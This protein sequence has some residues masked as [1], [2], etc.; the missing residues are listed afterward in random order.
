MNIVDRIK[1][2]AKERG[3]SLSK[4][5]ED[6]GLAANSIYTWT[7][8]TPGIDKIKAVADYFDVSVDYLIGR[9]DKKHY[10]DLSEKEEKDLAVLAQKM[11]DGTTEEAEV[12]FEGEPMTEEAKANLRT[13]I[14]TALEINKRA[15][16]KSFT[17]KKYRGS[18]DK[19]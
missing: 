15:A 11:L 14:L 6:C 19:D 13:A 18:A 10:Y 17:P 1:K 9:S 5:E 12:N 4:V 3:I 2:L 7:K 16:K 8:R